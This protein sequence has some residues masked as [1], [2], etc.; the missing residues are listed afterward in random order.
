MAILRE[1]DAP[2]EFLSQLGY[3]L[4]MSESLEKITPMELSESL[5]LGKIEGY[6]Q[7]L[8]SRKP[9]SIRFSGLRRGEGGRPDELFVI[10]ETL[11]LVYRMP[12]SPS[13]K[14]IEA[15][16]VLSEE[17]VLYVNKIDRDA[18]RVILSDGLYLNREAAI[19]EINRCLEEGKDIYLRGTIKGLQKNAG[20][21]TSM[22]AAYVDIGNLG[23][24]GIVPIKQWSAGFSATESFR[25]M[26]RTSVGSI[27]NFRVT[28]RTSVHY[29]GRKR[30]AYVCS[31]K[32]YHEKIGYNPWKI[33]EKTLTKGATVKVKIV[34]QGKSPESFF[35]ALD[36]IFDL[37]MLCYPDSKSDLKIGDIRPGRYYYG[38]VQSVDIEKK[39]LRV[40]LTKEAEQGSDIKEGSVV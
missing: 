18:N 16:D 17:Y 14:R 29:G 35:G 7:L 9:V 8:E 32:D 23:I 33:A 13:G 25:E 37:N 39:F 28:G 6:E 34:E 27:V 12:K 15:V 20:K 19:K 2:S 30:P 36:G 5:K 4:D 38:F 3:G 26:V 31:R 1:I 21:G 40:R 22:M 11:E 24:V 10:F